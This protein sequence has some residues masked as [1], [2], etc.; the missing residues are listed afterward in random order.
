MTDLEA[1]AIVPLSR[2]VGTRATTLIARSWGSLIMVYGGAATADAAPARQT[3]SAGGSLLL[4]P[5]QQLA[6]EAAAAGSVTRKLLAI[7]GATKS[8]RALK[9]V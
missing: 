9:A 8:L 6:A 1:R 5:E 7:I 3:P 2:K 4:Q